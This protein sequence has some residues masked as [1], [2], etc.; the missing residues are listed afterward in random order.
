MPTQIQGTRH[1]PSPPTSGRGGTSD[2]PAAL[3]QNLFP[4]TRP[5]SWTADRCGPQGP[6]LAAAERVRPQSMAADV[7]DLKAYAWS[8][9][10]PDP[11]D[12]RR[13]LCQP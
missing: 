11:D 9:A 7:G 1:R 6:D 8:P 10:S 2:P 4:L 5:R 3:E 13:A 12:R